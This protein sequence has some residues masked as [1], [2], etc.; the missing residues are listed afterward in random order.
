MHLSNSLP[1]IRVLAK[2]DKL[3]GSLLL[4]GRYGDP[5]DLVDYSI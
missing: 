1:E 5:Y 4:A 3:E 2:E